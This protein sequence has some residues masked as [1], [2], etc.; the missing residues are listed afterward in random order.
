VKRLLSGLALLAALALT[1]AGATAKAVSPLT[2]A[3]VSCS[4][5]SST[6]GD[7]VTCSWQA[8]GFTNLSAV[9]CNDNQGWVVNQPW[10]GS[11]QVGAGASFTSSF[12]WQITC[13]DDITQGYGS[14]FETYT[15]PDFDAGGAPAGGQLRELL[16]TDRNCTHSYTR[17]WTLYRGSHIW[18]NDTTLHV[19]WCG[20]GTGGII[21]RHSAFVTGNARGG[22]CSSSNAQAH[23]V[24]GGNGQNHVDI[25]GDLDWSC[26][27]PR[28]G[29]TNNWHRYLTIRFYPGGGSDSQ[30]YH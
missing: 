2:G 6:W 3:S 8:S 19:T 26:S 28:W 5:A 10:S 13:Y 11:V 20:S 4:P 9:V 30:D 15:P 14:F 1:T 12:T 17:D 24:G 18:H 22:V 29:L 7:T 16:G 21:Q 27:V 23:V 25:R